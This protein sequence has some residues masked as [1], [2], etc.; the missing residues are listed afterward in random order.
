[1][2]HREHHTLSPKS[3]PP[4]NEPRNHEAKKRNEWGF[5]NLQQPTPPSNSSLPPS[6]IHPFYKRPATHWLLLRGCERPWAAMTTQL[7]YGGL[8]AR[9][10]LEHT[11]KK[12]DAPL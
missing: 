11:I 7:L 9:L 12:H 1:M 4:E 8:Y 10:S 2:I 5:I 6:D 3:R